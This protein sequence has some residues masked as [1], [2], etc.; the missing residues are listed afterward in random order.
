M[1]LQYGTLFTCGDIKILMNGINLEGNLH[2]LSGLS[3]YMS[4]TQASLLPSE[5][6][7]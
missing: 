7:T 4:S 5:D 1:A 3:L 2:N 6:G